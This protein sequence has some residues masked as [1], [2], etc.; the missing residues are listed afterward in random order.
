MAAAAVDRRRW[1]PWVTF[2]GLMLALLVAHADPIAGMIDLWNRS[3]MYSHGYVVPAV[4]AYLV[5]ALR[6]RLAP[7]PARPA[8]PAGLGA[9]AVSALLLTV[10]GASG[11]QILGQV[12][13]VIGVTACALLAFGSARVRT[14]WMAIA[15][16]L[17]MVPFWDALTDRLHTP[18]QNLSASIGV[19]LISAVGIPAVRDGVFL[20]LPGITL[21]VARACSGINYLIAVLAL[22]L[23]LTYLAIPS[24]W[25]R[26]G[27]IATALVVAALSN[28]LRVALIGVLAYYDVG[29]PLHGPGHVLHGLFV[30]GIGHA[31]LLIGVAWARRSETRAAVDGAS[32]PASGAPPARLPWVW[33]AVAAALFLAAPAASARGSVTVPLASPLDTLPRELGTWYVDPFA[34]PPA[35]GPWWQPDVALSRRYR[36]SDGRAIDLYVGYYQAQRQDR[37]L[38]SFRTSDLHRT[39]TRVEILGHGPAFSANAVTMPDPAGTRVAVFWYELD[40]ETAVSPGAAKL[41]TLWNALRHGRSNGAVVMLSGAAADGRADAALLDLA[42]LTHRAL[43]RSLPG[44]PAHPDAST[45][46]NSLH[47]RHPL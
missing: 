44:R 2:A 21:E 1:T 9:A 26:V 36:T 37:E 30:A 23:P 16:L 18:F 27:L 8:I 38:V 4:S 40:G 32:A 42:A 5:W 11:V 41:Q 34:P 31:V 10:S 24:V 13:L 43:G 22:G 29:S 33:A 46:R 19:Q 7:L 17:L 35:A 28:G 47:E 25:R 12:G 14:A 45:A 15:Y 39:A 20:R 3:P 6:D